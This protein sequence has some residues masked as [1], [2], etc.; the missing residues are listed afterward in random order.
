MNPFTE[1][2]Q[3]LLFQGKYC[4][5]AKDIDVETLHVLFW[6]I[7]ELAWRSDI[8]DYITTHSKI[9]S[10]SRLRSEILASRREIA[11]ETILR[12]HSG[13]KF[14]GGPVGAPRRVF[15]EA[16]KKRF[17]NYKAE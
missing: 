2:A 5:W 9:V 17:D 8:R 16:L 14:S 4:Q 3:S 15:D 11:M 7:G 10:S 12:I 13:E 6:F 1:E